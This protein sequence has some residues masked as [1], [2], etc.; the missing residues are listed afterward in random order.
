MLLKVFGG[1]TLPVSSDGLSPGQR[2]PLLGVEWTHP[3]LS[4][5]SPSCFSKL[6]SPKGKPGGRVVWVLQP[7][8]PLPQGTYLRPHS[9]SQAS[10]LASPMTF[11]TDFSV[12]GIVGKIPLEV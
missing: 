11:P 3:A 7:G 9:W 5:L 4:G 6:C 1:L 2:Q 10:D 12:P 8:E